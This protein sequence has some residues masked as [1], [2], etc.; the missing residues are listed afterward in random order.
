MFLGAEILFLLIPSAL[1]SL[2]LGTKTSSPG[3]HATLRRLSATTFLES[4]FFFCG[5]GHAGK[6]NDAA[7]IIFFNVLSIMALVRKT[8]T[9][10]VAAY[11]VVNCILGALSIGV[12]VLRMMARRLGPGIG[13][14]DWLILLALVC[15]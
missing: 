11:L 12:V 2:S 4:F 9:P 10:P 15:Q 5:H 3:S 6:G 7:T 14:D 1:S 8:M 13:I